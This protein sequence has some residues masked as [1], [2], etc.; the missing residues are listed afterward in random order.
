MMKLEWRG[1]KALESKLIQKSQADYGRVSQKSLMEIYTRGKK[2][3][4]P[5]DTSE[6]RRS[7]R[8]SKDEVGYIKDYGPHVEYGHVMKNGDFVPGQYYLKKN[9]D[10]QRPIYKSDLLAKLKE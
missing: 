3:G 5:V 7:L 4:T 1:T 2:D 10:A 6:L 9:V 8:Y